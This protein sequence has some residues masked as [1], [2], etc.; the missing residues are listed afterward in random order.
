M[1]FSAR[2]SFLA[3]GLLVSIGTAT[4]FKARGIPSLRFF[5]LIPLI[6]AVQQVAEGIVWLSGSAFFSMLFL[7]I[8]LIVWPVWIPLSIIQLEASPARRAV[9][10]CLLA[11]GTIWGLGT[12]TSIR[13]ATTLIS[14]HI[15]Y[16]LNG[17][18][19][20]T[21]EQAILSYACMTILPFFI[22]RSRDLQLFGLLV[23]ISCIA[24]YLCWYA[25]F[26]SVWCFFAAVLS[27]GVYLIVSKRRHTSS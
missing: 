11:L 14:S 12:I 15:S 18:P 26:I 2:V 22:A 13:S 1:C 23:A 17:W 5:A 7:T 20:V 4:L 10:S 16:S 6:F 19:G 21:V 9:L 3:A 25:F 27:M 24:T 8:A